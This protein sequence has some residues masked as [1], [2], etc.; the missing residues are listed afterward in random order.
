MPAQHLPHKLPQ[1]GN[2]RQAGFTL[3]ITLIMLV[4]VTLTVL[5]SLRTAT[6]EERMA[7]NQRDHMLAFQSDEATLRTAATTLVGLSIWDFNGSC[8]GGLCSIGNAPDFRTYDWSGGTKHLS[9]D[10]NA[11]TNLVSSNLA[12]NPAYMIEH[13]GQIKCPQCSG[14]WGPAFRITARNTGTNSTTTAYAQSVHRQ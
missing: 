3:I 13:A 9:L 14:G 5:T 7:G 11:P 6:L 12:A 8:N 1:S 10:R 4:V 2:G